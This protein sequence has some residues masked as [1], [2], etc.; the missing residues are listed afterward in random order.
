MILPS[1]GL[2]FAG[3]LHFP[4]CIVFEA[5][6]LPDPPASALD[7]CAF[8]GHS[9]EDFLSTVRPANLT[10]LTWRVRELVNACDFRKQNLSVWNRS[11]FVCYLVVNSGCVDT[12]RGLLR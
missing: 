2:S 8:T 11:V 4:V 9:V 1:N 7:A 6:I 12:G 10:E 5:V 3:C